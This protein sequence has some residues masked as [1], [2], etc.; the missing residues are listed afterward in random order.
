MVLALRSV[1]FAPMEIDIPAGTLKP[2][3]LQEILASLNGIGTE[4]YMA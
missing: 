3:G 1:Q 2:G 4:F